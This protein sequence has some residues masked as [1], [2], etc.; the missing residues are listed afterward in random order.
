MDR[1]LELRARVLVF[2]AHRLSLP[3]RVWAYRVLAEVSPAAY[4]PKLARALVRLSADGAL[5][6]LPAVRLAL[7]AEA[8]AAA[9]GLAES[10]PMRG[11][12]LAR[13]LA[14]RRAELDRQGLTD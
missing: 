1:D 11:P 9:G 3:Q 14:A 5:L 10:D 2:D 13:A 12:A 4:R 7:L 6:E 8:V